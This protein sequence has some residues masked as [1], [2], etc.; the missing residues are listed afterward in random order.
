MNIRTKALWE[1]R[2]SVSA[3]LATN[4]SHDLFLVSLRRGVSP[5]S[6]R[7][8]NFVDKNTYRAKA[9][10]LAA[11]GGSTVALAVIDLSNQLG[12]RTPKDSIINAIT[13]GYVIGKDLFKMLLRNSDSPE[14]LEH[15][16]KGHIKPE[17]QHAIAEGGTFNEKRALFSNPGITAAAREM[18]RND[19]SFQIA[20]IERQERERAM[21]NSERAR[22]R[23]T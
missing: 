16:R 1:G 12:S 4:S 8:R 2:E 6:A 19:S 17:T 14:H 18:L 13:V 15:L 21:I 11:A 23:I 7:F 9:L 5:A 10:A 3:A 20:L 22:L